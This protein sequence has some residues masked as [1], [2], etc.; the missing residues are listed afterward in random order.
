MKLWFSPYQLKLK[1]FS[2]AKGKSLNK[3]GA[4][5]RLEQMGAGV[6][7]SDLHP[8]VELG[9]LPMEQQ[10]S[11]YRQGQLTIQLQQSINFAQRDARARTLK[12]S[13]FAGL[14]IPKSHMLVLDIQNFSREAFVQ[15]VAEGFESFKFKL[16]RDLKLEHE[17]LI[18]LAEFPLAQV[19]LRFD[20]NSCFFNLR[21]LAFCHRRQV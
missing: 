12:K 17:S 10:L 16:G 5:L 2:N 8:T 21:C 9:D 13:L 19:R 1:S 11:L 14:E 20:F 18:K 15:A 7:Y 6:G 3:S 4:L